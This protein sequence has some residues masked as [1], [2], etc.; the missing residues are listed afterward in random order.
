MKLMETNHGTIWKAGDHVDTDAILPG[1]FMAQ[2][3]LED[4]GKHAFAG[5][6]PDFA[7]Q[8]RKGDF[9]LAGENFGCGSSREHAPLAL[10]FAGVGAVVARSFA[11]IFYRNAITIGLPVVMIAAGSDAEKVAAGDRGE[12]SFLDAELRIPDRGLV[13]KLEPL[14]GPALEILK[15][16]GLLSH[17][18]AKLRPDKP[19]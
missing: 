3:V 9:I 7:A 12:L 15:V 1:R 14:A 6:W 18:S 17:L 13:V 5:L 19:H 2:T 4:L 16:G 11:R 8:V 10:K